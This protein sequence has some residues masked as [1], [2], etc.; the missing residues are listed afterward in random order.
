MKPITIAPTYKNVIN[1]LSS[2]TT[3]V[4]GLTA[5]PGR[6]IDNEESNRSLSDFFHNKIITIPDKPQGVI[7]T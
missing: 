5:T 2:I 1:T 6:T 4:I 7:P 3:K